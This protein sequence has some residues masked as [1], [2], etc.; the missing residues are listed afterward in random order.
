MPY[1]EQPID[2]TEKKQ[3]RV[4]LNSDVYQEIMDYCAWAKVASAESFLTQSALFVL[5]KDPEWKSFKKNQKKIAQ[6]EEV[7]PAS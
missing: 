5:G 7:Y 2:N 3:I 6:T 4:R 1:I